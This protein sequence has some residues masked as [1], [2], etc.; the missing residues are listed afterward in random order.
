MDE[1]IPGL[2]IGAASEV[3]LIQMAMKMQVSYTKFSQREMTGSDPTLV[4]MQK[5]V[6][7]RGVTSIMSI[8]VIRMPT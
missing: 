6:S 8:N 1:I 3:N 2:F 5:P 4:T 7:P